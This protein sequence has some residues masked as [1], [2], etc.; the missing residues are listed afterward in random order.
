MNLPR[1]AINLL[2]CLTAFGATGCQVL[3]GRRGDPCKNM[4]Y[5]TGDPSCPFVSPN[6]KT[7]QQG[8]N[9]GYIRGSS[10]AIKRQY[11]VLQSLN[12][13]ANQTSKISYYS[14]PV[15]EVTPDGRQVVPHAITVPIVE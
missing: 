15:S 7:L 11:W 9:A 4:T 12:E 2:L 14:V 13:N 10:D 6:P 1:R 8:F 5:N 3:T